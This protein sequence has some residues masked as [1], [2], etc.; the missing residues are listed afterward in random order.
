[1]MYLELFSDALDNALG[2]ASTEFQLALDNI[3][4]NIGQIFD[5]TLCGEI[6][7]TVQM[8]NDDG[9]HI[10]IDDFEPAA[11]KAREIFNNRIWDIIAKALNAAINDF[12][13]SLGALQDNILEAVSDE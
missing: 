9:H 13:Y 7:G 5:D 1:M 6:E 12:D 10:D 3:Q 4:H 2:E 8:C 11:K